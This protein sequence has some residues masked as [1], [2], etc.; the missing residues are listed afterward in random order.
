MRFL[1][2]TYVPHPPPHHQPADIFATVTTNYNTLRAQIHG[3]KKR[4]RGAIPPSTNPRYDDMSQTTDSNNLLL[5]I[6]VQAG[7]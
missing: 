3:R 1:P 4:Q 7:T 5:L 6:V 2:L